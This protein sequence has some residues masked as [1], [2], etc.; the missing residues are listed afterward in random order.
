ML[1]ISKLF[2]NNQKHTTVVTVHINLDTISCHVFKISKIG[3]FLKVLERISYFATIS[4]CGRSQSQLKNRKYSA[5]VQSL[6]TPHQQ[7]LLI[8]DGK[9]IIL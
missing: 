3:L 2:C 9:I 1:V 5:E 6:R 4:H 8:V 7:F